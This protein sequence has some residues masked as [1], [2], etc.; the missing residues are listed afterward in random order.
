MITDAIHCLLVASLLTLAACATSMDRVNR[1]VGISQP[2][3]Y[4]EG[5]RDGCDSGQSAAGNPYVGFSK[6]VTRFGSD[7]LYR[8]GWSDG[9]EVCKARYES[10]GRAL[11]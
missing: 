10:I 2:L 5:Y 7:Q 6:N 9:F 3:A 1:D 8:Q 4:R 11:N